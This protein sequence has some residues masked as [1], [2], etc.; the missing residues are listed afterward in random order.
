M[1]KTGIDETKDLLA[2]AIATAEA[3]IA[4]V[5]D[6]RIGFEDAF[7][8]IAPLQRAQAALVGSTSIPAELAELDAEEVVALKTYVLAEFDIANDRVEGIIEDA[9]MIGLA[10]ARLFSKVKN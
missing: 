2:F 4:S 10:F 6:G 1:A 9:L 3:V 7:R 5:A 8:M